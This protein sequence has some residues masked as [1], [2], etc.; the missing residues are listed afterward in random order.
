LLHVLLSEGGL[1]PAAEG[2]DGRRIQIER[3]RHLAVTQI[4]TAKHQQFGLP[5]IERC[6]DS[7]IRSRSSAAA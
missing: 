3:D 1:R 2:S 6:K 7:L 4:V 5:L